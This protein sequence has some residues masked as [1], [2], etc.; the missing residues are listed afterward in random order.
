MLGMR[1]FRSVFDFMNKIEKGKQFSILFCH[2]SYWAEQ[3][4]R[5]EHW[6]GMKNILNKFNKFKKIKKLKN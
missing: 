4:R 1:D 3:R 6:C 2:H 5:D